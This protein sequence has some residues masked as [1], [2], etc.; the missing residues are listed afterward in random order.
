ML[1]LSSIEP[2]RIIIAAF[3]GFVSGFLVSFPVG[4]INLTII[5]EGA[6]RG[7]KWAALI[8]AGAVLMETIYCA[9][10]FMGFS[11]F[12]THATIKAAFELISFL[13]MLYLGIRFLRA[14]AVEEHNRIEHRLEEKLQPHS[15]FTVGFVRVLGNPGVLLLWITLAA[16]FIAHDWVGET[17]DEKLACILGVC[18]G[19]AAWFFLLCYGV[20][21]GHRKFSPRTLLRMEHISG[22]C[23]L[24]V[25]LVLGV[26]L[27][28][29]IEREG[30]ARKAA[31]AAVKHIAPL[32]NAPS[33]LLHR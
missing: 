22:A 20:S 8:A 32:T 24:V 4:P 2:P 14:K 13:L 10:A 31:E 17:R 3:T 23:L 29:L 6:R 12:F 9:L 21:R 25:A 11:Q 16:T 26:R 7:F 5:N 28:M 19:T 18:L 1:F 15:A 33:L 27:V 30:L